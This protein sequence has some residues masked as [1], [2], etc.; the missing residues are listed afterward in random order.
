MTTEHLTLEKHLKKTSLVS[1]TISLVIAMITALSVG[2][3]FYYNTKST[4]NQHGND[5]KEV[6]QEV[7]DVNQK[8]NDTDVFKGISEERFKEMD[9]KITKMDEKLDKLLQRQ[10][11]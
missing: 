11:K 8:I 3:G 7:R 1:N 9:E 10:G 4:L 6:K 5:I 2:Y